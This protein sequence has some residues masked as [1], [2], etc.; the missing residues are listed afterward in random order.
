MS[1]AAA[2]MKRL[3]NEKLSLVIGPGELFD[4]L[5][6]LRL[7][8]RKVSD[9][10]RRMAAAHAATGIEHLIYGDGGVCELPLDPLI[11]ELHECNHRLWEIED[12]IRA[13]DERIWGREHWC[14]VCAGDGTTVDSEDCKE[15]C[16]LARSVYVT[17][18]ERSRLKAAIDEACGQF[19]EVKEYAEYK[20]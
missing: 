17:N 16:R 14:G 2:A 4:R 6:I 7:K 10:P 20:T 1:P 11:A 18:D 13:L 15:Y 9:L 5:T 3:K 12:D 19:P 8:M